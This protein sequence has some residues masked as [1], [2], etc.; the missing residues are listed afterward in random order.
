M[1][2]KITTT[3]RKAR[4]EISEGLNH[5]FEAFY[6]GLPKV[7]HTVKIADVHNLGAE[8]QNQLL[9]LVEES[10]HSLTGMVLES[11]DETI[12][13][14][15]V[16]E[17]EQTLQGVEEEKKRFQKELQGLRTIYVQ[18]EESSVETTKR[19]EY[20][21]LQSS[22]ERHDENFFINQLLLENEVLQG[23]INELE[24]QAT[25]LNE[26]LIAQDVR[27][28]SLVAEVTTLSTQIEDSGETNKHLKV[29]VT[30]LQEQ[31]T[32]SQ[33]EIKSLQEQL[34]VIQETLAVEREQSETLRNELASSKTQL[35]TDEDRLSKIAELEEEKND[36][37]EA[38][39]AQVDP[40]PKPDQLREKEVELRTLVKAQEVEL[41]DL[42]QQLTSVRSEL[43]Q[44][45]EER[46]IAESRESEEGVKAIGENQL[47]K[48]Q[49]RK[50]EELPEREQ[51]HTSVMTDVHSLRKAL[52][53]YRRELSEHSLAHKALF[54]VEKTGGATIEE[55]RK[56][57]CCSKNA[58]GLIVDELE[59]QGWVKLEILSEK[60]VL[61]KPLP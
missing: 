56:T 61:T 48:D 6:H 60:V 51:V 22:L 12:I 30:N 11:L 3:V 34:K 36:L 31:L 19:L 24:V 39:K 58:V 44:E 9:N 18:Q 23:R 7:H 42:R 59:E 14:Q 55:L 37:E 21:R 4:S 33:K 16:G 53:F 5:E 2:R 20:E 15:K 25:T 49:N 28:Q 52:E 54:H 10:L 46:R 57:L 45:R 43:E 13:G 41:N 38:T 1:Q 29:E 8:L 40:E 35:A 47:L 17:L 50:E 32:K 27:N 26:L